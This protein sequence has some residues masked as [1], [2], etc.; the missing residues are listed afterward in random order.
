MAPP[1]QTAFTC[2]PKLPTEIRL[3]IWDDVCF[4]PRNIDLWV[5]YHGQIKRR[6]RG[7][8]NTFDCNR[9]VSICPHPSILHANRESRAV[10]LK[11]YELAFG[12]HTILDYGMEFSTPAR[13]YVNWNS[14]VIIPMAIDQSDRFDWPDHFFGGNLP[15]Q[16]LA[17]S[18]E[19]TGMIWATSLW[20]ELPLK[21]VI[22]YHLEH[23]FQ[24]N[25]LE[26]YRPNFKLELLPFDYTM[27]E[28][29][30]TRV[31]GAVSDIS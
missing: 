5:L 26:L 8:S 2:F 6:L 10:G 23:P 18:I 3:M 7:R 13:I 28:K 31:D 22:L 14:D 29:E 25:S 1:S 24:Q 16:N 19:D 17:M 9:Y 21:N 27:V 15:I 11:Y 12:M 20:F 4:F 30:L